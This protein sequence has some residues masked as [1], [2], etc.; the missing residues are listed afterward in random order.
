MSDN[1]K[2]YAIRNIATG[3]FERVNNKTCWMSVAAAKSS[4]SA[5]YWAN[6]GVK[7]SE[8]NK[9]QIIELTEYYNMYKDLCK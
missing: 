8:Q 3:E 9:Y 6:K 2:V 1:N 5:D 4:F 7:F